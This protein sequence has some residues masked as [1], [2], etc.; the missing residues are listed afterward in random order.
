MYL[1]FLIAL[2]AALLILTGRR[3]AGILGSLLTVVTLAA[4]LAH[5]MTDKLPISL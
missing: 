4:L 3:T 5:H 1:I 2:V